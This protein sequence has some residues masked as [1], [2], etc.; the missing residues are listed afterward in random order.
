MSPITHGEKGSTILAH[1]GFLHK[2]LIIRRKVMKAFLASSPQAFDSHPALLT[3]LNDAIEHVTYATKKW[4]EHL[5]SVTQRQRSGRPPMSDREQVKQGRDVG[6]SMVQ[7]DR[8][9][10]VVIANI[11]L[12]VACLL[13]GRW[14][15]LMLSQVSRRHPGH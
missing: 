7:A 3:A 11:L 6:E 10:A 5:R 8:K 15:L 1:R 2:R 4:K 9:L 13:G 12:Y 14:T